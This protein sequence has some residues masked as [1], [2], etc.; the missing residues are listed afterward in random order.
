MSKLE[1]KLALVNG[2][3]SLVWKRLHFLLH[4]VYKKDVWAVVVLTLACSLPLCFLDRINRM[5]F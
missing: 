4:F 3:V 2:M 1:K 5:L